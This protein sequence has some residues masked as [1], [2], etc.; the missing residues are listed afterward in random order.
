MKRSLL[1][2]NQFCSSVMAMLCALFIFSETQA[3]EDWSVAREWNEEILFAI[4]VDV[5]RPTI[6]A[7]NLYHSSALMYD[8]W[9]AYEPSHETWLL[10]KTRGSYTC[11]FNGVAIPSD[12]EELKAAREEAISFALYRFISHRYQAAPGFAQ[13]QTRINNLMESKGYDR[14]DTSQNYVN[15]GPAQLGNYLYNQMVLYGYTDGANEINNYE[16]LVYVAQN[17]TIFPQQPGNPNII[18]PNLWQPISVT[19]QIGQDGTPLM[20]APSFLSPE[21]GEMVPFAMTEDD[22]VVKERDGHDWKVYHDPG[23]PPLLD[24]E[25]PSEWDSNY[26][27]SFMMVSVWQSHMDPDDDTQWDISPASI[28]N[29]PSYPTQFDDYDDFYN[30]TEGGE[31]SEGHDINPKTGMPY[32]P[33]LV[34]RADYA[35]V[36]AEFWADGPKS[37]TPPGHWYEIVNRA[38]LDHPEL[39]RKWMGEGEELDDLEYD[40]KLY[41]TLGGSMYDAAVTAWSIKGYYDY[42]RPISAIRYMCDM[43]QSTDPELDNYHPAGAPLM[44]GYIEVVEEGD[45]LAGESNEHVG[46]IKLYTWK[47]PDYINYED[48][49]LLEHPD[50]Y[51]G[52]G[53]ILGENWW[54][55]QRPK[56]VSPPFAGYIS[57]H[58]TFSSTAAEVM[59]R[60]TGDAFFPG[61]MGEFEAEQ[62]EFLEFEVGP[63]TDVTLQWATYRDAS[64]QC[65]LSRIWGGIHPPV[66]DI[67]GRF[68]GMELGEDA[69][70]FANELF[71]SQQPYVIAVEANQEVVN[72]DDIGSTVTLSITFDRAMNTSQD[73]SIQFMADNPLTNSLDFVSAEW[74]NDEEYVFTYVLENGEEKLDNIFVQVI[75]AEDT[76]GRDQNIHI[77]ERPI[78]I[79]TDRPEIVG[80]TYNETL[81]NDDLSENSWLLMTIELDEEAD[82]TAIPNITFDSPS[83]LGSTMQYLSENS[84]WLDGTHFQ[85]TFS[86]VDNNEE[87]DEIGINIVDI[88]DA[89]GNAQN[90][91]V[92]SDQFSI[93]TRNPEFV[94][95]LVNEDEFAVLNVQSIGNNALEI[96]LEFDEIMNTS[97]EPSFSFPNDNPIGTSL[98]MNTVSSEWTNDQ[99]Y[100]MNF[101]LNS[102][103]VE[104]F[105][106]VIGLEDFFDTAGNVPAEI[107]LSDLFVID[108]QKPQVTS[109]NPSSTII[110]DS[111]VGSGVFEVL[112]QYGEAMDMDQAPV[113]SLS[114]DSDID[115]SVFFNPFGS[116]WNDEFTFAALFTVI[117]ENL[118]VDDINVEVNYGEDAS[119]NSQEVYDL[120][121]WI[122][123]DTRNPEVTLLFASTYEVNS[124]NIIDGFSLSA[125]FDEEM[126]TL[127]QP[128][129][130]F[131]GPVDVSSILSV[132]NEE[133]GWNSITSYHVVYD[134]ANEEILAEDIDVAISMASD[135]AGN[136]VI[137]A[138][139]A[140][141]FSININSV[142]IAEN[143]DNLGLT[144][145]PN[146]IN[147]GQSL[148]FNVGE[149][150]NDAELRIISSAGHMVKQKHFEH[151]SQGMHEV[152]LNDYT[153]GM[154]F[155]QIQSKEG[156]QSQKLV[157]LD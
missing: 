157:V 15:G 61:G 65:S 50:N 127:E 126:N 51:A 84:M 6:H 121:N 66:D 11:P 88:T 56:F 89:A 103:P 111:D 141:F 124:E 52:A 134:V 115:G 16:N 69:V 26:K 83:D 146:P 149:S 154:Y 29:V 117:D 5:G 90:D 143:P 64:D 107:Q 73:P 93:D 75:G 54:T 116:E 36:L 4:S 153:P 108:T 110:S 79:D 13:I 31:T 98:V 151:L 46:K 63:S 10:G 71:N 12:P 49:V 87:V 59:E 137:S 62:D 101:N 97:M 72:I 99:T 25:V 1:C 102:N 155:I 109:M 21:W 22:L 145:Y 2:Q 119:G 38:V 76:E 144:F 135:L 94:N 35:R 3:Q 78:I 140:D 33:Q 8:A 18:D 128:L 74:A 85:A 118:E 14:F 150:L 34:K 95:L 17:D 81:L 113:V 44:P 7:R 104:M 32:E 136:E 27:W 47:G 19:G 82:T 23:P 112:I 156:T 138:D 24:P 41:L 152:S 60:V 120:E 123:L 68:I 67:A 147:S 43:G 30:F 48:T 70:N 28:G 114:A 92:A 148:K 40:I 42:I 132:N 57:G 20:S 45:P 125:Q 80:I 130:E 55:W 39:E 100:Q 37:F 53:W 86:V 96:T 105:D 9:A 58:S 122:N 129:F 131:D 77:A 106:I 142:G 91:F 133:S 139:Y